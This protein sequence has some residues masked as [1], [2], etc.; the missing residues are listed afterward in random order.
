M[1]IYF[2]G[3]PNV[4]FLKYYYENSKHHKINV[5]LSYYS[6]NGKVIE[7][8]KEYAPYVH[9]FML[10]SGAYSAF[11]ADSKIVGKLIKLYPDYLE[12]HKSELEDYCKDG[13]LEAVFTLDYKRGEDDKSR[14]DNLEM[15]QDIIKVY[16]NITPVIHRISNENIELDNY[17][18]YKPKM[19]AIGQ[20]IDRLKENKRHLL[21]NTVNRIKKNAKCHLL[22]ITNYEILDA[23]YN[24]DSCDS[25]SW[26]DYAYTGKVLFNYLD[27]NEFKEIT[28][29]C[30]EYENIKPKGNEVAFDDLEQKL[31]EKFLGDMNK[32]Y[33]L[34]KDDF[35][36]KNDYRARQIANIHY[37]LQKIAYIN[38]KHNPTLQKSLKE[39]N[40]E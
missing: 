38:N 13:S 8:I 16:E 5:M 14:L 15:Y 10:D 6:L 23:V 17:E 27:K 33:S 1:D 26:N 35:L 4:D 19:I 12:R 37:E 36:N 34:V 2:A 11:S 9:K 20:N 30:A 32:N 3:I 31:R 39:S 40:P 18:K 7:T 22:G 25:T 21:I 28:L 29:Y 24:I